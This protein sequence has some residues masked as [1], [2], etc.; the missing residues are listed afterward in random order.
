ML[1]SFAMPFFLFGF[2]S[3]RPRVFKW[4]R[5]FNKAGIT[6]HRARSC[7][8]NPS[9]VALLGQASDPSTFELIQKIHTLQKRLI[10]KTEEVVEK[11]LLLQVCLPVCAPHTHV[12]I[13]RILGTGGLA[14]VHASS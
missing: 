14:V 2:S 4:E 5:H 8:T 10:S 1:V 7:E 6:A 3:L 13:A 12:A 11:E 9:P